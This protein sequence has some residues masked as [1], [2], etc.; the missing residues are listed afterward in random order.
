[1]STTNPE[2]VEGTVRLFHVT[3]ASNVDSIMAN[4]LV[5]A[6]GPRAASLSEP[7]P[8]VYM[9]RER[10]L[11]MDAVCG[12]LGDEFPPEVPLCCLEVEVPAGEVPPSTGTFDRVEAVFFTPLPASWVVSCSRV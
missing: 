6:I 9:F 3:P 1:M 11:V 4:G 5:P 2:R 7:C 10:D 8:A 12:W